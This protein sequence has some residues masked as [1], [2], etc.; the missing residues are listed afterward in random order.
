MGERVTIELDSEALDAAREAGIDLSKLLT[1][2]LRR[3]LPNLHAA[4]REEGAR[5]WY[6]ENKDGIDAYNRL[7]DTRG[8]FSD[9]ARKI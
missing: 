3:R 6:E 9:G 2:A 7:I 1:H 8:L 4:A 5:Q